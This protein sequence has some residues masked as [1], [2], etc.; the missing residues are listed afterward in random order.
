M[1]TALKIPS[2]KRIVLTH[3]LSGGRPPSSS[4]VSGTW[5]THGHQRGR[6][7]RAP[8]TVLYYKTIIELRDAFGGKHMIEARCFCLRSPSPP[9]ALLIGNRDVITFVKDIQ[10]GP[11]RG[12]TSH[13]I[14]KC[15]KDARVGGLF[16]CVKTGSIIL[17]MQLLRLGLIGV[18]H[19][20]AGHTQHQQPAC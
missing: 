19:T 17:I 15:T 9:L 10:Q 2:A 6:G 5:A 11:G 1:K 12:G 20:H 14:D 13:K 16:M 18:L 8:C 7:G 4:C 3:R